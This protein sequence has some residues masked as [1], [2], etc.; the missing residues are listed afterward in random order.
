MKQMDNNNHKIQV[1]KKDK[2][3]LKENINKKEKKEI[4]KDKDEKSFLKKE[5]NKLI[6]S[7]GADVYNYAK[8]L[9]AH[10]ICPNMFKAHKMDEKIMTKMVDWMIEVLYAYKSD[11]QTLFI[12]ASA[13]DIYLQKSTTVL[14]NSNMHLI[15]IACIYIASKYEDVI[16]IRMNSIYK[17]IAHKSFTE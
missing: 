17:K 5:N 8:L 10:L 14:E 1:N 9:E 4:L 12:A 3:I 2:D 6:I 15:G 7:Y 13:L 11:I 16:P